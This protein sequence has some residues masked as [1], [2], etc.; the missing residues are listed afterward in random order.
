[1]SLPER[2]RAHLT[3]PAVC[4]PM[5]L[6][7]T[8]T[9][10]REACK[11][12]LVGALPRQNARTLGKFSEWVTDIRRDLD[13]FQAENPDATVGPLAVN[14]A[15]TSDPQ[16][17]REELAVC[18]QAGVEIIISSVGNP[19]ALAKEVHDWGGVLFHDI[20]EIR[21]AEKAVA[22]G[23]DGLTCIGAG[24]GGHSGTLSPLTL[25]P[26]IREMFDGVIIAAGAF[27][28]GQ[29]IRA[30]EILG[31]DLVYLGTRFIA[32][33]ESRAPDDYKQMLVDGDATSLR[34]DA[35]VSGVPANWLAESLKNVGLDPDN[36]PVPAGPMR[37]DHLPEEAKPWKTI[38]SAGQG[39]ELIRDLPTAAELIDRLHHEYEQACAVPAFGAENS[40]NTSH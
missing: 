21:F 32:T 10:V 8:P 31:A 40:S 33:E 34:Y 16:T 29:S 7:S 30:A 5:F 26:R 24:G 18:R 15:T 13:E 14:L 37:H 35:G 9:L 27:T 23:A 28:T 36:M 12:G 22:A 39:I 6:V 19:S 38:W 2:L 1:M 11:G 4:A 25:I 17:M 3:L 20:T